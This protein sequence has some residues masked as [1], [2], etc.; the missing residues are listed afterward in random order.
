MRSGI[1]TGVI[2]AV[3]YAA[4]FAS[5]RD[6]VLAPPTGAFISS[7]YVQDGY[8]FT[9]SQTFDAPYAYLDEQSF[10][11]QAG[12]NPTI[13]VNYGHS[14]NVITTTDGSLFDI[15]AIGFADVENSGLGGTVDLTLDRPGV[16]PEV[17]QVTLLPGVFTLQDFAVDGD[18]VQSFSF[19]SD[20]L[21]HIQFGDLQLGV[22]E[23]ATW[24]ML[25]AGIALLG[26]GLRRR[27][28][29]FATR[30]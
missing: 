11:W 14:L 26:V 9:N 25:M 29:V 18:D 15:D 7:P 19:A 20:S 6:F 16:A 22:P 10:G 4:G 5:A 8:V 27:R 13:G 23:P 24:S 21:Y 28:G 30:A 1:A 17:R 3:L 2:L 12:P